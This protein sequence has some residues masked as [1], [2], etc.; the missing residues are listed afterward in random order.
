MFYFT[1]NH[2]FTTASKFTK[3]GNGTR[4]PFA[5][6]VEIQINNRTHC[7]EVT[8]QFNTDLTLT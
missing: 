3:Y 6:S 2:G 7:S 1:W 8:S 5:L 4:R